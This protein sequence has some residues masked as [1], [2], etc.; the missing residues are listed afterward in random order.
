MKK[1]HTGFTLIELMVVLA[2]GGILLTLAVPSF[3]ATLRSNRLTSYANNLVTAFN[4]ARS[5][6]IGRGTTITVCGSSDQATC[7]NSSW[8]TGWIVMNPT[9]NEVLHIFDPMKGNPTI[10]SAVNSV[11][12]TAQGFISGGAAASIKICMDS[13]QQG[14]QIDITATG[15]PN[16][17]SPYPDC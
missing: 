12:Y 15:R 13:G 3:T 17:Q 10:T 1:A 14:R 2:I 8:S 7:T 11:T 6:A 16:N 9:T 5:E 4:L